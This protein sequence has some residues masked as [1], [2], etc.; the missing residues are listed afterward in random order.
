MTIASVAEGVGNSQPIYYYLLGIF[1]FMFPVSYLLPSVFR[2][3]IANRADQVDSRSRE[4]G[5]LGDCGALDISH[6]LRSPAR[7]S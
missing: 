1:V 5:F 6:S 2:F 7:S 3:A 4:V